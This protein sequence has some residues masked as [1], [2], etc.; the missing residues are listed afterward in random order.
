MKTAVAASCVAFFCYASP[1]FAQSSVTL[2]GVLDEGLAYTSNIGGSSVVKTASGIRWPTY[3]GLTGHE[4]LGGGWSALFNF[5]SSFNI[6]TGTG[7][8]SSVLFGRLSV[9]GVNSKDYGRV[10]VGRQGD[11]MNDFLYLVPDRYEYLTTYSMA[12]GNL[13]RLAGGQL[14]NSV[15]YRSG[16][17]AGLTFG[18]MYAFADPGT[19]TTSNGTGR[20][21]EI[22]Y[23][24]SS[25]HILAVYT[26]VHAVRVA[27]ASSLG[28]TSFLGYSLSFGSTTAVPLSSLTIA[29]VGMSYRYKDATG[30]VAYTNVRMASQRGSGS[31]QTLT[32]GGVYQFTPAF[33]FE[34]GAST[35]RLSSSRWNQVFGTLDYFLS[36]RTDVYLTGSYEHTSGPG[37]TAE[38]ALSGGPSTTPSQTIAQVGIKHYF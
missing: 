4:D 23:V 31:L 36:K 29:A 35:S 19:G 25:M 6:N 12:P 5:Q 15:K 8:N 11:F 27:P 17:G 22:R 7:S 18:A 37:Q 9:I 13:D 1:S 20:S 26:N 2:F 24:N 21:F 14:S 28:S 38:L 10:T 33:L 16:L 34:G 32:L 30:I 3:W